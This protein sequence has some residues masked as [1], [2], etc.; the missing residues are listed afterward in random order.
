MLHYLKEV[1]EKTMS[2]AVEATLLI[3]IFVLG[4]KIIEVTMDKQ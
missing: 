1:A 3:G 4:A 2:D